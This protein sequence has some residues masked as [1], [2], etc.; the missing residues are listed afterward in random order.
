MTVDNSSQDV[1]QVAD[2][3]QQEKAKSTH[4]A[5]KLLLHRRR[6]W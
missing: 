6:I 4:R 5:T 1:A 3:S 2:P